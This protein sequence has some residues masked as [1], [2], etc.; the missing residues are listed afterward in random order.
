MIIVAPD[1]LVAR[2]VVSHLAVVVVVAMVATAVLFLLLVLLL[3]KLWMDSKF[4]FATFYI[5][6]G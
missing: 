3:V 6:C 5:I 1:V 2:T 4:G